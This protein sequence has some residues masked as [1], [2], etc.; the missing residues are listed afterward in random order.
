MKIGLVLVVILAAFAGPGHAK[1]VLY[2]CAFPDDSGG[3]WIASQI[4]VSHDLATGAVL[5]TDGVILHYNEQPIA[6][7]VRV[8]TDGKTEFGWNLKNLQNSG[9]NLPTFEFRL[10]FNPANKKARIEA[11]PVGYNNKFQATGVCKTS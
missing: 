7:K 1:P 2:D 11:T 4:V 9:Q 5:V 8:L 10:R 3:G 6:G